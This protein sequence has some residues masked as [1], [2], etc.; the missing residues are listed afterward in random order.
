MI[1]H[2]RNFALTA[3]CSA[4]LFLT[5]CQSM[6]GNGLVTP[7][8]VPTLV[9]Y[10]KAV[11]AV[12]RG[13]IVSDK[14]VNGEVVPSRQDDLYF[15]ASGFVTRVKVKLGD[16]VKQG[17]LLAEMQV[18]DL[19]NQL[20]AANMDLALAQSA[21]EKQQSQHTVEF[22]K[23]QIEVRLC[24][25]RV[26]LARLD[27]KN[28]TGDDYTRARLNLDMAVQSLTLAQL[29]AKQVESADDPAA[30][31]AVER[32][33]LTVDRVQALLA[34]R[35]IVAPY[36]GIIIKNLS[37]LGKQAEAFQVMFTIGDP[38]QLVVR[39]PLDFTLREKMYKDTEVYIT[40][41]AN[42][43]DQ[44]KGTYLPNFLPFDAAK[45]DKTAV[46]TQEYLYFTVPADLPKD[47]AQVGQIVSVTVI[48]G[49]KDGVLLVP[50]AAV[51]TYRGLNFVIVLEGEKRRR[52]EITKIGLQTSDLV[53]IMADLKEGDKVLGQ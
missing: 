45:A 22:Q 18:D 53:E 31:Q 6:G 28:K 25:D 5:A 39:S 49:R 9:S 7:T 3:V 24:E 13:S 29:A 38:Q 37:T 16:A 4:L 23:A 30:V 12:Q 43:G 47:L 52:V 2:K 14:K 15:S 11:Y 21:L 19:L 10:E 35:R 34:E 50:P 46:L 48:L 17:D 44:F 41:S 36:D 33:Q 20:Q 26:E 27:L 8:P 42:A 32:S 1:K 51:R 40:A